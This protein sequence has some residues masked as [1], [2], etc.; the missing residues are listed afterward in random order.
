MA[1]ICC[2]RPAVCYWCMVVITMWVSV[3][4]YMST[5]S[6]IWNTFNGD[7]FNPLSLL[8]S[9]HLYLYVANLQC[10]CHSLFFSAVDNGLQYTKSCI[11]TT[12]CMPLFVHGTGLCPHVPY[13]VVL[14][15]S[16]EVHCVQQWM[17]LSLMFPPWPY[18]VACR[19]FKL[20]PS[21]SLPQ[22]LFGAPDSVVCCT[23]M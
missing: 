7:A 4:T 11:L 8:S 17:T 18:M 15:L 10:S 2:S 1:C 12:Y 13:I 23:E 20:W 9:L 6:A 22:H 3:F 16:C 19:R 21:Q 14:L 5:L